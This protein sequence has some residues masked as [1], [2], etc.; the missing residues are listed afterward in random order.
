MLIRPTLE[1]TFE[2]IYQEH[3]ALLSGVLAGAWAPTPIDSRLLQII[4]LH[5]TPWRSSDAAPHFNARTGLPHDFISYPDVEKYAFYSSG[6]DDLERVDPL[7]A[8]LVSRRYAGFAD[9]GR[10]PQFCEGESERQRRLLPLLSA[11]EQATIERDLSWID[12]FDI[13]SLYL[14]LSG[15]GARQEAIPSWVTIPKA[16]DASELAFSWGDDLT[17]RLSPW[18]F[19]VPELNVHIYLRELTQRSADVAELRE[20]WGAAEHRVRGVRL[21]PR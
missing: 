5:D 12:F 2:C 6:T 7:A 14:C 11:E 19:T 1:G 17:L 20:H 16:P 18:P 4:G 21:L 15:P 3:H 9:P 8:Y 10:S 13:F